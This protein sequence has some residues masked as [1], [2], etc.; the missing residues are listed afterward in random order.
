MLCS[1]FHQYPLSVKSWIR[2]HKSLVGC[3]VCIWTLAETIY[4]VVTS[5]FLLFRTVRFPLTFLSE[6]RFILPFSSGT[7]IIAIWW[8][9]H[10]GKEHHVEAVNALTS[11]TPLLYLGFWAKITASSFTCLILIYISDIPYL[12][13]SFAQM[14]LMLLSLFTLMLLFPSFIIIATAYLAPTGSWISTTFCSLMFAHLTL[15]NNSNGQR[16]LSSYE[17]LVNFNVCASNLYFTVN[18][19][20]LWGGLCFKFSIILMGLL[21]NLF[22]TGFPLD[23]LYEQVAPCSFKQCQ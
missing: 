11:G 10:S 12:R 13:D 23:S 2:N 7:P 17:V 18:I 14:L 22:K 19:I 4:Y 1:M 3:G 9:E 8:R 5:L 15:L 20:F 21:L 16:F 6:E